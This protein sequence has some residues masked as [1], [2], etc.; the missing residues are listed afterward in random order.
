MRTIIRQ[1]DDGIFQI[2]RIEDLED[3]TSR[4]DAVVL[5]YPAG[6]TNEQACKAYDEWRRD[7][8]AR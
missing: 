7:Q 2:V 8:W 3:G 5:E 4:V 1:S 6:T